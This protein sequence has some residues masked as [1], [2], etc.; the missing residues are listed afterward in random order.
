MSK[1]FKTTFIGPDN[2][3]FK[4]GKKPLFD[5][6][7]LGPDN[8]AD[9]PNM[10]FGYGKGGFSKSKPIDIKKPFSDIDDVPAIKRPFLDLEEIMKPGIGSSPIVGIKFDVKELNADD[11]T[12]KLDTLTK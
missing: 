7:V 12:K 3:G 11:L 1:D 5:I 8:D 4:L 2:K 9:T 10:Q 6:S